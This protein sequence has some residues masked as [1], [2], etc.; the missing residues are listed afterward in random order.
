MSYDEKSKYNSVM[1][2][3]YA[4]M[5][6]KTAKGRVLDDFCGVTGLSRKH[7]IKTLR[8]RSGSSRKRGRP[9]GGTKGGTALLVKAWKLSD[10]L[11]G[12][13]L[14]VVLSMYLD[15]IEHQKPI[16]LAVRK[17]VLKMSASTIDRRLRSVKVKTGIS[18][19]RR[20]TSLSAHRREIPLKIDIWPEQYPKHPGWIEVD[21]V[22]FCGGSMKGS[23][24]WGLTMTDVG[25]AWT[26]IRC[27][28]NKGAV[29]V[30]SCVQDFITEVPFKVIAMNS[31]NGGEFINGH[32]KHEFSEYL[33]SVIRTRSR[34]YRKNDNAHV[35]QKNCIHVRQLFGYGRIELL[36][37]LPLMNDICRTQELIK[38]LFTPTMRLLSKE[39]HG[40]RYIKKYEKTPKTPAQRL[41]ESPG[42]SDKNKAVISQMVKDNDIC[43]LRSKLNKDLRKLAVILAKSPA[44][45]TTSARPKH[46][47]GAS[48]PRASSAKNKKR[49]SR[50]ATCC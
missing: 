46:P 20:A 42:V 14:K 3:R 32:L 45:E 11:C 31:D 44:G 34:S 17:E 1:R 49:K 13:L 10:M 2:R 47:P 12:K 37:E 36:N 40:S 23:F 43:I 33:P 28:W 15:S 41:L 50:H 39:R 25:S 29:G 38:N 48:G 16:S 8:K 9:S 6:T 24:V 21:T 18:R 27:V 19:T 22:A 35:E 30:C 5:I 26:R 7:A 4:A